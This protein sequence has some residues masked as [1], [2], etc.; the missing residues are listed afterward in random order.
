MILSIRELFGKEGDFMKKRTA[1]AIAAAG[2]LSAGAAAK[3]CFE[4]ADFNKRCEACSKV[5]KKALFSLSANVPYPPKEEK[6]DSKDRFSS[7]VLIKSRGDEKGGAWYLGYSKKS[8]LPNDIG[9][10]K[11]CIAGNT[12]LP[13]NFAKGVLDGIFVRTVAL[14]AGEES[15]KAVFA[16]VDCI[17]ISN[18]CIS[19]IRERLKDFC[20]ENNVS[21][22]NILSTHSHSSI[23][24]CGIWGEILDVIKYNKKA[25]KKGE[26]LKNSCDEEYMEFLYGVV[27]ESVKEAVLSM[28]KGKLY[29]AYM[30]KNSYAA[31]NEAKGEMSVSQRGLAGYVWDRREP[32][33]CSTQLLRLRFKPNDRNEKETYI[34]N[35]AAHPYINGLKIKDKG[36]GDMISG[37]FVYHLGETFEKY[38]ANML[39]IN[40]AVAAVYPKRL[41]ADALTLKDQ[42]RAFGE[43]VGRIALSMTLENKKIYKDEFLS[44]ES[45]EKE[46][47]IFGGGRKSDYRKWLDKKGGG[48]VKETLLEPIME[49]S[50][51]DVN[52]DV[53]NPIFHLVGKLNIGKYNILSNGS[54]FTSFTEVGALSLG[55]GKVKAAFVPGEL[56]PAVL[57][58]S[59]AVEAE[60]SYSKKDFSQKPLCAVAGDSDLVVFGLCNDAIGYIIPDNDFLMMFLGTTKKMKK[61][62]GSHYL[63]IFSFGKNTAAHVVKGFEKALGRLYGEK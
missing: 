32:I 39:F 13:A 20:K 37:D 6:T 63:E 33:D 12:R 40:G 34:V 59:Y 7:N 9:T 56:E 42:A 14:S 60:Y 2:V 23:D 44:P 3:F 48:V 5:F 41:Y 18:K 45:Y 28:K 51:N 22:L 58:G 54:G 62:F 50:T 15:E 35:F 10:K 47:G 46:M 11:Y 19:E 4:N 43:E 53:E 49:L 57:S 17:G 26:K 21:S 55:G 30:G 24:T 52:L 36:N 61:L 1:A 31:I 38:G 25:I 27:E 8:I 16:E 29:S